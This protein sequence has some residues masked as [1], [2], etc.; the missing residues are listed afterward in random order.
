MGYI[1][2]EEDVLEFDV[3]VSHPFGVDVLDPL[4]NLGY[5]I[6]SLLLTEPALLLQ[7][8]HQVAL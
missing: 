2:G 3:P 1:V 7:N 6:T 5:D 8:T 4:Q